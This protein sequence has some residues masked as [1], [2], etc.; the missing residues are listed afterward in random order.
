[1]RPPAPGHHGTL[2]TAPNSFRMRTYRIGVRNPCRL[3]TYEIGLPQVLWNA[4]LRTG[5]WGGGVLLLTWPFLR[6]GV[7]PVASGRRKIARSA[8]LLRELPRRPAA[9]GSNATPIFPLDSQLSTSTLQPAA[10]HSFSTPC[11][12]LVGPVAVLMLEFVPPSAEVS[13]KLEARNC[14]L[15]S[16]HSP[17]ATRR[18][19]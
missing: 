5:G 14:G 16:V 18:R 6:Q 3:C 1:M 4:H 15:Q 19:R 7:R 10:T 8:D 2:Q 9:G 13:R 17:P 12:I 11:S